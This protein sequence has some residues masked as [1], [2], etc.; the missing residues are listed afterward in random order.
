M[1]NQSQFLS[2]LQMMILNDVVNIGKGA[3]NL[4]IERLPVAQEIVFP[5]V[6]PLLAL[7]VLALALGVHTGV[8]LGEVALLVVVGF[9]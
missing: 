7:V 1:P 4:V 8:V 2:T 3:F 5:L 9:E 6:A